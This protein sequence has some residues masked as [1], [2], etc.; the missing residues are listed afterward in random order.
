MGW[1]G[2]KIDSKD[3]ENHI[4][5]VSMLELGIEKESIL[6]LIQD[7]SL[8]HWSLAYEDMGHIKAAIIRVKWD[9]EGFCNTKVITEEEGPTAIAVPS[10]LLDM[11]TPTESQ[12]AKEWREDCYLKSNGVAA[13]IR[14]FRSVR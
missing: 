7:K 11:L 9:D 1:D 5:R 14:E 12:Y 13:V 3:I 10:E 4:R 8:D 2:A 6:M